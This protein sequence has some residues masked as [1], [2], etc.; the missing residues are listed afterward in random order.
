MR[1]C[2]FWYVAGF[3]TVPAAALAAWALTRREGCTPLDERFRRCE[4]A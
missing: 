3:L 2:F 1:R 4:G